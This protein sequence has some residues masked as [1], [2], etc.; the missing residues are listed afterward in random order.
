MNVYTLESVEILTE[1]III[2]DSLSF[3]KNLVTDFGG[4]S[5]LHAS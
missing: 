4:F 5:G 2:Q 1:D 3:S